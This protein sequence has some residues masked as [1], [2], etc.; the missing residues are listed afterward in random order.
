M[1]L[2][3]SERQLLFS[4]L[5]KKQGEGGLDMW[6]GGTLDIWSCHKEMKEEEETQRVCVTEDGTKVTLSWLIICL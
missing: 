4:S 3:R 5:G 2:N 6:R 1:I